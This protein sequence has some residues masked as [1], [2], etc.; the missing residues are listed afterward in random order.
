M[1]TFIAPAA[2]SRTV[3]A[4]GAAPIALMLVMMTLLP[5]TPAASAADPAGSTSPDY[6]APLKAQQARFEERLA[7]SSD[8]SDSKTA[9]LDPVRAMIA[10]GRLDEASE[11]LARIEHST[12]DWTILAARVA[13]LRQDF[14][15]AGRLTTPL[16][17][18]RRMLSDDE[19]DLVYAWLF[20]ADNTPEVAKRTRGI[21]LA[22]D[23]DAG[24][25]DLLAAGRLSYQMLNF[26]R[27]E[28]CYVRALDRAGQSDENVVFRAAARRG[29]GQVQFRRRDFDGALAFHEKAMSDMATPDVLMASSETL[30]RLGRT[31]EAIT[32]AE[33]AVKLN[34]YHDASH[35]Y[36]GNGYARKNYTELAVAFPGKFAD[37]SGRKLMADADRLL[38]DGKRREARAA[39][40]S[41]LRT[42][43]DW[44][45]IRVRIASYE[46]EEGQY[47]AARDACFEALRLC[48]EYGRA[49]ATLA[50]ALEF[51]RFDID[52]HRR[53]YE[54]RFDASPMPVLPGIERY[55]ANWKS[56][57]PRHQKR[58][59]LSVEPWKNFLPVLLDG[60]CTHYV[61]PLHQ[62]LSETPGLETLRDQRISYDSRLWDDV[63]GAGG[64]NTVTGIEDVE[65][66]I[67]D[68][69]NTVLHELTHQVHGVMTADQSR[70]IQE[71]YRQAKER[72]DLT[73]NGFLSR[74]AGGSVYEYFAEGA[75]ALQSKK[76]DVFDSREEVYERLETMDPDLMA[77]VRHF[78]ALADVE[79]NYPIAYVNAGQD[80]VG[81][82]YVDAGVVFFEK[83]LHRSPNEET[84]LTA[85]VGARAL[86]GDRVTAGELA[87][88]AI[89]MYPGSGS[90]RTTAADAFWRSGRPLTEVLHELKEA[91]AAVKEEDRYLVDGAIGSY[92]WNLGQV[93]DALA[94]YDA[95]LTYQSDSPEGLWGKA[96]SL[97]LAERWDQAF[98]LYEQAVRLR[99]GVVS[100]RCDVARDLIRA[101]RLDHA[102]THLDEAQL[103]EA[104]NPIAEA[105]RGWAALAAGRPGE[106]LEHAQRARTWGDW[107]DLAWIIEAHALKATGDAAAATR[108]V[109]PI[110]ARLREN[111]PPAYLYR[112]KMATWQSI[113]ELPV[114][115]RNL[116]EALDRP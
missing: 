68:R 65:R 14:E 111:A 99:T 110:Q 64:Y 19:R 49:H 27:A 28:S 5:M 41:I 34:R 20:A 92:S 24:M 55:V 75:N 60:G 42:H 9:S 58:V 31:D 106:A 13:I 37:E 15:L 67:F 100:L 21:S 108:A 81:K 22:R 115:E 32:A 69:Y 104:E 25:P 78:M 30:I 101:G 82:G 46:F 16:M 54:A 39:Y 18:E 59:A 77:R 90:V 51:Q 56:L 109:A 88:R 62:L 3:A 10:T 84:A 23:T 79:P 4:R 11:R 76:R 36:L 17:H 113:H 29:L 87:T 83:A 63:R 107:C 114:V 94:A 47:V 102:L 57:S 44:A 8:G 43:P 38:A 96:A 40:E 45:D 61:K 72:D 1:M 12:P 95:L 73:K 35:Y 70:E 50:K 71:L 85:L 48:P 26:D 86:K 6:F 80:R 91:R 53:D 74:Y 112:P 89:Q 7:R 103:L 105:L 116:L 66:T 97:A 98:P 2:P 93:D 52:V 33:W